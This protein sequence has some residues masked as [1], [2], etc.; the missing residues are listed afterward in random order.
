[1]VTPN[2]QCEIHAF[3][4]L[5]ILMKRQHSCHFTSI[6]ASLFCKFI[7]TCCFKILVQISA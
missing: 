4:F 2:G 6:E 5:L 7:T 3:S 1:M